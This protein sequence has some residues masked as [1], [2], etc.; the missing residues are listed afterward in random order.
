MIDIGTKVKDTETGDIGK[1]V[2]GPPIWLACRVWVYW[3]TGILAGDTL[4]ISESDL[5]VMED[6][7]P[8]MKIA[9]CIKV[10]ID[11]GYT[12]KKV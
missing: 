8:S 2:A 10:L 12:V 5:E 4:H 11:A 3:E 9:E 6:K 1:V 7:T